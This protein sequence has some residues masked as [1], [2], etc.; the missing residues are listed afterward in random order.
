VCGVR[1]VVALL[2]VVRDVNAGRLLLIVDLRSRLVVPAE[3]GV[4][5]GAGVV[6]GGALLF[7]L[8]RFTN[9]SEGNVGNGLGIFNGGSIRALSPSGVLYV[10][11]RVLEAGVGDGS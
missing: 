5:V 6:G 4:G 2:G 10:P 8:C 11:F 9:V 7:I 1:A 3:V